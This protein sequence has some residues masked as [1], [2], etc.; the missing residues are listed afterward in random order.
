MKPDGNHGIYLHF[1]YFIFCKIALK[2]QVDSDDLPIYVMIDLVEF[3][4]RLLQTIQA[5]I[6]F[7]C[8]KGNLIFISVIN[9]KCWFDPPR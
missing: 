1:Q 4:N 7:V 2:S 5:D 3:S 6:I 8:P 9:L